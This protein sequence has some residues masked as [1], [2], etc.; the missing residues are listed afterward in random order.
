[1]LLLISFLNILLP[2]DIRSEETPG[3]HI[4]QIALAG[5]VNATEEQGSFIRG[6]HRIIPYP[7]RNLLYG[8]NIWLYYEI[9]GLDRSDLGDYAWEESYFI[10][11]DQP[12]QGIV[13]IIPG[14]IQSGLRPDVER[15]FMVD[16]SVM[17][18]EYEG[19][20]FIIIFITD[21]ISGQSDLSVAQF[22]IYRK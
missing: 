7:G 11:P 21:V 9:T 10:I 19:P 20:F 18:S 2:L 13:R 5:T 4:S 3:I 8:E 15:S 1:M 22:N 16:L 17:E 12:G 6:N 14:L